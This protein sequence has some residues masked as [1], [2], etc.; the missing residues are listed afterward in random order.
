[1]NFSDFLRD[2]D[3]HIR[4][5]VILRPSVSMVTGVNFSPLSQVQHGGFW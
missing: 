1:M 4:L 2:N 3:L 5:N